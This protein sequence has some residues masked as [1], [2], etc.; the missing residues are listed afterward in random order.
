VTVYLRDDFPTAG[1]LTGSTPL[2]GWGGSWVT[3][4]GGSITVGVGGLQPGSG[5]SNFYYGP[6]GSSGSPS[7]YPLQ[8]YYGAQFVTG[9]TITA[10]SYEYYLFIGAESTNGTLTLSIQDKG[11]GP[12][13]YIIS[14]LSSSPFTQR[15]PTGLGIDITLTPSTTYEVY[16]LVTS[17]QIIVSVNGA[18]FS[19]ITNSFAATGL[20]DSLCGISTL[21][22]NSTTR[23]IYAASEALSF[24]PAPFAPWWKNY[25]LTAE[26]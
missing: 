16:F 10:G 22:G 7:G 26:S 18:V 5:K 25:A 17:T 15:F 13:L 24:A 4:A 23:T 19:T 3:G 8:G 20:V 2:V 9:P 1:P 12:K 21:G 14:A 6:S 11:T